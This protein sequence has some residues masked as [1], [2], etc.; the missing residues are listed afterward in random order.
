[1][2]TLSVSH[3]SCLTSAEIELG[4]FT[5]L[6]GPQASGKSVLSKLIYFCYG[7][8]NRQFRHI[9][10]GATLESCEGWVVVGL[11][12]LVAPPPRGAQRL[13]LAFRPARSKLTFAGEGIQVNSPTGCPWRF[14]NIFATNIDLYRKRGRH[15]NESAG[16]RPQLRKLGNSVISTCYG[17]FEKKRGKNLLKVLGPIMFLANCLFRQVGLFLRRSGK[18]LWPSSTPACWIRLLSNLVGYLRHFERIGPPIIEGP[19]S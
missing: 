1:M 9:E 14:P 2:T 10:D 6:I 8:L 17:T 13:V 15:R 5:I 4:K 18:P 16:M 19:K 3:F 7:L 12:N 11:K